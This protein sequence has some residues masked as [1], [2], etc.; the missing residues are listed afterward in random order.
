MFEV[1]AHV[2][3]TV[4]IYQHGDVSLHGKLD[5]ILCQG[6]KLMALADDLKAGIAA[7]DTETNNV[8]ARIDALVT[9]LGNSSLSDQEKADIMGSLSAEAARLKTLATD[10]N[11][12]VPPVPP[13]LAQARKK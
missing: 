3:V 12:P 7:L 13:A 4:H 1:K 2:E 5:K 8:A 6:E 9:K 10:P 11:A